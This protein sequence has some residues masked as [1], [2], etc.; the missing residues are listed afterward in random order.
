MSGARVYR[1]ESESAGSL[2]LRCWPASVNED[3]VA[4][5]HRVQTAAHQSGCQI[6]PQLLQITSNGNSNGPQTIAT[7]KNQC[8]EIANWLPGTKLPRDASVQQIVTGAKAIRAFHQSVAGL[9]TQTTSPLSKSPLCLASRIERVAQLNQILPKAFDRSQ[10]MFSDFLNDSLIRA[11]QVL[12]QNWPAVASEISRSINEHA[13]H[14]YQTQYVLRDVHR[15]H[16]LFAEDRAVGLID[17]DAIRF[18]LPLTDLVRWAGSFSS[19]FENPEKTE[20]VWEAVLAGYG[21]NL[22]FPNTEGADQVLLA[23]ALHFSA[24]WISLGNWIA[25]MLVEHRT[26][27]G[28]D[29]KIADRIDTLVRLALSTT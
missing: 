6:V 25:W 11:Q 27:P 18:D 5:V 19:H 9:G 15:D 23:K 8:W 1:C 29:Q 7:H 20:D 24:T 21:P 12:R 14:R 10:L 16:I 26:F 17:F 4:E 2:A 22:S 28:Q 13:A 3:R